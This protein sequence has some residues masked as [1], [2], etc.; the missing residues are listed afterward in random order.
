MFSRNS[1]FLLLFMTFA[2]LVWAG[3]TVKDGITKPSQRSWLD[4][5]GLQ[6]EWMQAKEATVAYDGS[7]RRYMAKRGVQTEPRFAVD[8][9]TFSGEFV[10]LDLNEN[11]GRSLRTLTPSS[12]DRIY[13]HGIIPIITD[14]TVS[15]PSYGWWINGELNQITIQSS[16]A[17][18]T[19]KVQVSYMVQ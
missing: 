2:V 8:T 6:K 1:F 7:G 11:R 19:R 12:A 15:P 3:D 13:V 4:Q 5:Y 17:N 9:V 14:S 16:D 18:D 10:T